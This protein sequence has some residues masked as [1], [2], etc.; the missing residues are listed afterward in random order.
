MGEMTCLIF[1]SRA[2][3]QND[4]FSFFC[5]GEQGLSVDGFE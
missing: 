2:N 3:I 1:F 4:N 5:A